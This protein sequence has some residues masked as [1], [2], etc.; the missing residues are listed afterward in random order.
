MKTSSRNTVSPLAAAATLAAVFAGAA[1]T[2]DSATAQ[3]TADA[4][5]AAT[6]SAAAQANDGTIA[7]DGTN[8]GP[9]PQ[10]FFTT[11]A[12]YFTTFNTNLA[13]FTDTNNF[14]GTVWAGADYQSGVGVEYPFYK[15]LTLVSV[16]R[17]AD[18]AGTILS[19][20]GDLAITIT[21]YDTQLSLGAGLGYCFA[22]AGDLRPGLFGSVF[23][24][25]KKALTD[26]TFAGVRLE[27]DFSGKTPSIPV[28]S[29][30][31]GFR[32]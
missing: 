20:Q 19:Q 11:V 31:A 5:A 18:V 29:I 12:G 21:H 24:E 13:T 15:G 6:N 17:N 3:T 4:R 9:T 23:A 27:D 28:V 14:H 1:L 22:N 25:A 8:A 26:N 30:F 32:F 16:T 10:S 2:Q 7:T